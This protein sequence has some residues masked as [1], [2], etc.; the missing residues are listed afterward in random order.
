M[1]LISRFIG[2]AGGVALKCSVVLMLLWLGHYL[3]RAG[4]QKTLRPQLGPLM[5]KTLLLWALASL[6]AFVL[7]ALVLGVLAYVE[8]AYH[9]GH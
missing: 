4:L 6:L 8:I 5:G 1:N 9:F 2:V 7:S 3:V